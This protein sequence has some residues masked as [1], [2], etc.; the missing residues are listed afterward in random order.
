VGETNEKRN[1]KKKEGA[2]ILCSAFA[3][4]EECRR[5]KSSLRG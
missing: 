3:A 4:A 2:L 5:I 1:K